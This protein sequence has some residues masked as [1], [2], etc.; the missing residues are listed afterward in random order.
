MGLTLAA[1]VGVGWEYDNE[2]RGRGIQRFK[3]E[4]IQGGTLSRRRG[5]RRDGDGGGHSGGRMEG[6]GGGGD[7]SKTTITTL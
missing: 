4:A 6:K 1:V 7:V 2:G 5:K 3:R